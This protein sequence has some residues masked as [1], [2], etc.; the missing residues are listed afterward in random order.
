MK[1]NKSLNGYTRLERLHIAVTYAMRR[2]KLTY[3]K[4]GPL[5]GLT[6]S[7]LAAVVNG[8]RPVTDIV[9]NALERVLA[10]DLTAFKK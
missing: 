10:V 5:T 7:Y 9:L 2:K 6:Y 3:R 4:L 1:K 8:K